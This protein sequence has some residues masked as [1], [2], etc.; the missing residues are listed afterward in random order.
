M[1]IIFYNHTGLVSGAERMLLLLLASVPH[2]RF[3]VSLV[4]PLEGP[5][6]SETK[7]LGF[8]VHTAPSLTA[9][10]TYNPFKLFLYLL[11]AS[12]VMLE[13]RKTF[14]SLRP[15]LVHANTVRA[16]VVA[17]IATI[18][19]GIPVVWHIHDM[20]PAHPITLGIRLVAHSSPRIHLVA[21]SKAA[22]NTLPPFSS[23]GKTVEV[24]PNG[25]DMRLQAAP[26]VG[27]AKRNE[28]QLSP[29][30][31][32]VGTVGLITPRKGQLGVIRA[33]ARLKEMAPNSALLIVGSAI[34]NK[35]HEY[36]KALQQE[37]ASL[38]LRDSVH[39][40]GQR[41]DAADLMQAMDLL[42]LNSVTEP[43]ALVLLEAMR[44][45]KAVLATDCGGPRE[46]IEHGI[47][48][49]IVPVGDLA[50]LSGAMVRMEG[51]SALRSRYGMAAERI[52]RQSYTRERYVEL[53]SRR[54]D[55]VLMTGASTQV[56]ALSSEG[57]SVQAGGGH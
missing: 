7:A 30:T 49:E 8:P 38:D 23:N 43:F 35:D 50:A 11:S 33:F 36:L 41:S 32:I 12:K 47:S 54:Y 48:G 17:T 57:S 15:D 28:L 27:L 20:L 46:I 56:Q 34:F 21:C 13:T 9:R 40:L 18:G 10:F 53:W 16:G 19:T 1:R 24:I 6:Q 22:A 39:F 37:V 14:V 2:D 44:I 29:S 5:L 55:L 25:I 26:E 3:L 45:G 31:F 52:V 51:D 42:V 4:C